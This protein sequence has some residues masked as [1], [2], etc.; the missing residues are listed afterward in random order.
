MKRNIS[1]EVKPATWCEIIREKSL[2][3]PTILMLV[4]MYAQM[5]SG[6]D[7]ILF[8]LKT[9]LLVSTIILKLHQYYEDS[10]DL[11]LH[12]KSIVNP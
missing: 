10:I 7:A 12:Y 8:Y 11:L 1:N 3:T 6:A 4:L 9:L 2:R 5:F